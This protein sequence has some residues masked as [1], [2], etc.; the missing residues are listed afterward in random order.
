MTATYDSTV[1]RARHGFE[2][3]NWPLAS[4][5]VIKSL[6]L[7][8]WLDSGVNR[9][10]LHRRK[11]LDLLWFLLLFWLRILS[12]ADVDLLS[13]PEDY[14]IPVCVLAQHIRIT[15]RLHKKLIRNH[16]CGCYG[17]GCHGKYL[18]MLNIR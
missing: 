18:A 5:R 10:I 4:K 13:N 11:M 1:A 15:N 14:R 8:R 9:P 17:C 7:C 2:R 12:V 16:A 6:V 3:M